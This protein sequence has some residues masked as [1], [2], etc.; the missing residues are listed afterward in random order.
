V[1][2]FFFKD[3]EYWTL[4]IQGF[5]DVIL[6]H[7]MSGFSCFEGLYC[8]QL[9]GQVVHNTLTASSLA[10]HVCFVLLYFIL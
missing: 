4:G 5:C 7:L 6:C 1:I 3:R 8:L 10:C 9:Q 2:F